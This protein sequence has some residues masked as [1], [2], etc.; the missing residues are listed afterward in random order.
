MTEGIKPKHG[1]AFKH[2]RTGALSLMLFLGTGDSLD[3]YEEI[4]KAEYTAERARQDAEAQK[5]AEI[6]G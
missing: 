1:Y 3:N 2:K 5:H 4:S 6:E